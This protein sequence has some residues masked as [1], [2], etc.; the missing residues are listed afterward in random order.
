MKS[1]LK[2]YSNVKYIAFLFTGTQRTAEKRRGLQRNTENCRG[3]QRT[4]E[5]HRELQRNA[6]ACREVQRNERELNNFKI[7]ESEGLL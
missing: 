1:K 4:A 3:T 7:K 6:E 2:I 5:E